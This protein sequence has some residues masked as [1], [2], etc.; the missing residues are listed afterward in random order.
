[1][2]KG[3]PQKYQP[4]QG[5]RTTCV[6]TPQLQVNDQELVKQVNK[7]HGATTERSQE[8]AVTALHA[9]IIRKETDLIVEVDCLL[10]RLRIRF[11]LP[12]RR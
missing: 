12:Q 10:F 9:A 8:P 4:G 7:S 1:M 6:S 2:G 5:T 3:P 11:L